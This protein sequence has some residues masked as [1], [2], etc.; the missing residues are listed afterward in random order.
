MNWLT[1]DSGGCTLSVKATPRASKTE[2]CG[3][4]NGCLR[5]RLQ[6]PPVDGKANAVLCEFLAETLSIPKRRVTLAA[7]ATA[8][9]KRIRIEGLAAAEVV[10]GL[11][12]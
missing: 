11:Q 12:P 5:I 8:R 7:G 2:V 4:E 3:V 1:E 10:A 6:A 9:L